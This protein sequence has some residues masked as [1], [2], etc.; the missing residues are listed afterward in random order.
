MSVRVFKQLPE[1]PVSDRAFAR[2]APILRL[3]ASVPLCVAQQQAV[4][5][6]PETVK[7]YTE[8]VRLPVVAYDDR[9]RFDP[10]LT[11]DDVLVLE[12]GVPQRV[13]SVRR[14]PANILLVF[15]MGGQVTAARAVNAPRDAA[16]KLLG[17][18]R[19]GA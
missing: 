6:E 18:L 2:L 14:V 11:A 4:Q 5:E 13:R 15:D 1:C 16:F 7:V 12:D 8:E 9:E 19:D 17:G 3:S 10:T